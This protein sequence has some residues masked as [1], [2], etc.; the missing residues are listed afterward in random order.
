[1]KI[2][3]RILIVDGHSL[4][5]AGLRTL[6]ADAPDIE[7]LTHTDKGDETD[8]APVPLTPHLLL[9]DRSVPGANNV[10][11]LTRVQRRYPKARVLMIVPN[12]TGH[13]LFPHLHAGANACIRKDAT[14]AEFRLAI[15]NVLQGKFYLD[16]S[17]SGKAAGVRPAGG[18]SRAGGALDALT[19]R[20]RDVLRLVAAGKSS[21][22]IAELLTLSV[23][24]VG[25]HRANLMAKL[26]VH[27]AAGLTAYAIERGLLS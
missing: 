10:D 15:R 1:M 21:K 6:L 20:E 2:L 23:K 4:L 12:K 7:V 26:D 13:F 11:A 3:Q 16:V 8:P 18:S 27:N 25:K 24:T 14:S 17:D 19:P 22:C 5:M 9:V